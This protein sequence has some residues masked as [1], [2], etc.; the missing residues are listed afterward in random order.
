MLLILTSIYKDSDPENHPRLCVIFNN[1]SK[2][3]HSKKKAR[4]YYVVSSDKSEE[5]ETKGDIESKE[6]VINQV[7]WENYVQIFIEQLIEEIKEL[8]GEKYD[9]NF[10]SERIKKLFPKENFYFY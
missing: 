9:V 6:T 7:P 1:V 2:L 3:P 4:D 5:E 10:V 8:F